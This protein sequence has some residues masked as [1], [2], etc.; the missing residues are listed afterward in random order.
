MESSSSSSSSGVGQVP[1]NVLCV[2]E[3]QRGNPLL[4]H[5]RNVRWAFT[6]DIIPD[7]ATSTMGVLFVTVRYHHR[8]PKVSLQQMLLPELKSLGASRCYLFFF[9]ARSRCGAHEG[10][11]ARILPWMCVQHIVRRID[12]VGRNY[13]LRVLL[14]LVDDESNLTVIQDLNRIAFNQNFTLVMAFSNLECARYLETFKAY[15]NKSSSSIQEREETE[16]L[17]RLNKVLTKVRHVNKADV[18]TLLDVFSNFS[19]ICNASEE[20]LLL[21]PGIGEKKVKRLFQALHQPFEKQ[22]KPRREDE[23]AKDYEN[24]NDTVLDVAAAEKE[25]HDDTV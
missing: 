15:E 12:E 8:H 6:K 24:Q 3:V 2:N 14:V 18:L 19:N 10:L 21:C 1:G 17:P 5:I 9:V 11:H 13:R 16:F 4:A 7:Y 23:A 20:Q 22:A 25:D